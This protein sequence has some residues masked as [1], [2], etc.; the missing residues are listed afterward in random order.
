MVASDHQTVGW[1]VVVPNCCTSYPIPTTLAVY[2][3]G[4][5]VQ[6][7]RD[8]M[9]IYKWGFLDRGRRIAVSSGTVHGMTGIHLTLY[10]SQTGKTLQTWDGDDYGAAPKWGGE[11]SH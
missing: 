7:I 1:L 3:S 11:V 2:K 8:G 6:R 4:R 10:D 9:M 5:V